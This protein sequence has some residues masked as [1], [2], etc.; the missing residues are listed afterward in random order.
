M[1]DTVVLTVLPFRRGQAR[2]STPGPGVDWLVEDEVED[3][4]ACVDEVVEVE[5]EVAGL[6]E[7]DA[8]VDFAIVLLEVEVIV[9]DAVLVDE[10]CSVAVV[11]AKI[12][13]EV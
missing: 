1:L 2:A 7:I 5:V 11:D 12:R 8:D 9:E 4:A 3:E 13:R 10:D 6:E